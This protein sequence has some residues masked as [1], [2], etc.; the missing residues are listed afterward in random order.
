M[1]G[2]ER[3][4]VE[5]AERGEPLEPFDHIGHL[6]LT[7]LVLLRDGAAAGGTLRR[8]LRA[9]ATRAGKPERFHET[10]T[11]AWL[12][13]VA[14]SLPAGDFV[15]W[16]ATNPGLLD[17]TLLLRFWRPETLEAG[18]SRWIPPDLNSLPA[19]DVLP[20]DSL[21]PPALTR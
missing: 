8:V 4:F 7:R 14:H 6:R 16:L 12:R 9:I 21:L 18:R 10:I 20:E 1:T 13:L 19:P 11:A 15:D 17:R 5:A 2:A 3:E